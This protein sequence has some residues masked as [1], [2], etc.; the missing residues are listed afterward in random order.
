MTVMNAI[1]M[2][3]IAVIPYVPMIVRM[4]FA[5]HPI[6]VSV[7]PVMYAT[8]RINALALAPLVVVMVYAAITTS[9]NVNPA[10]YWNR[11]N[12]NIVCLSVK[13]VVNLARV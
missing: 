1:P 4:A 11:K 5:R 13:T 8:K 9:V 12:K 3:S 10:M 6:P 2:Y 7:Y